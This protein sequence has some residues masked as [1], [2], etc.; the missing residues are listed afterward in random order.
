MFHIAVAKIH[1][2]PAG[3]LFKIAD[4]FPSGTWMNTAIPQ[5]ASLGRSLGRYID[6]ISNLRRV[7]KTNKNQQVYEVL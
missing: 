2:L 5:R 6:R 3:T 7:K 1:A 4:I